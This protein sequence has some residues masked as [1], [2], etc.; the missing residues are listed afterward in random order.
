MGSFENID[1]VNEAMK[2]LQG[3]R[4][5]DTFS[6][7]LCKIWYGEGISATPEKSEYEVTFLHDSNNP[8]VGVPE[9]EG[10]NRHV[11][12]ESKFSNMHIRLDEEGGVLTIKGKSRKTSKNYELNIILRDA[13]RL[14]P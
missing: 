14:M 8:K 7:W 11:E 1:A 9:F 3:G 13:R 12:F 5:S 2:Y 4:I 10:L 6:R